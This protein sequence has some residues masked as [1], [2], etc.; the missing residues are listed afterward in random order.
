[1]S[2]PKCH[3][4]L[5]RWFPGC[6]NSTKC[7]CYLNVLLQRLSKSSPGGLHNRIC[8]QSAFPLR[9]KSR[10]T[11]LSLSSIK[12]KTC[13][14]SFQGLFIPP[15][16]RLRSNFCN[17]HCQIRAVNEGNHRE[18]PDGSGGGGGWWI[19]ETSSCSIYCQGYKSISDYLDSH[20]NVT[21]CHCRSVVRVPVWYHDLVWEIFKDTACF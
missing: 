16:L 4:C 6:F 2:H 14:S 3:I 18:H 17:S 21:A 10:N 12:A 5:L 13:L 11:N 8:A 19:T 9:L 20:C 1:M 15:R 7:E